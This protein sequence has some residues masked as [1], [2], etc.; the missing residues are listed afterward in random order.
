MTSLDEI[1]YFATPEQR[2]LAETDHAAW[3][4]AHQLLI[5][6]ELS[7]PVIFVFTHMVELKWN[8]LA[9]YTFPDRPTIIIKKDGQW[10]EGSITDLGKRKE[11]EIERLD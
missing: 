6:F 8:H 5:S 3:N 7:K 4:K 1:G 2:L 10:V 11:R 9:I